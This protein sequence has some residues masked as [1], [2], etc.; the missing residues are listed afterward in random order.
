MK[1]LYLR[2]G[3]IYLLNEENDRNIHSITSPAKLCYALIVQCNVGW[4]AGVQILY[5]CHLNSTR[6]TPFCTTF[7][8]WLAN[9]Q[10]WEEQQDS[11]YVAKKCLFI[12]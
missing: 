9:V 2:Q 3:P 1:T 10:Q 4:S 7:Q 12:K 5:I 11:G 8:G 6:E